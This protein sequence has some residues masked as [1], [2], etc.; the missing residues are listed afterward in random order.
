MDVQYKCVGM[1][2]A[3]IHTHMA[4]TRIY[5]CVTA[6][7]VTSF[8]ETAHIVEQALEEEY[9]MLDADFQA[10]VDEATCSYI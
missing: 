2:N 8:L 1:L 10:G 6:R 7:A 9:R 4:R 3:C 5:T